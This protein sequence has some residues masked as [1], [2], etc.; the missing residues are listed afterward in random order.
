MV[1][2]DDSDGVAVSERFTAL[3][4]S[5]RYEA[6]DCWRWRRRWSGVITGAGGSCV[7]VGPVCG[8]VNVEQRVGIDDGNGDHHHDNNNDRG[9]WCLYEC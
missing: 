9:I 6:E 7:K 5:R 3:Y 8:N 2:T 1:L 4:S